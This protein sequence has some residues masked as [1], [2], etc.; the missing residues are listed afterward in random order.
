VYTILLST[1]PTKPYVREYAI[2]AYTRVVYSYS[3]SNM[4]TR[5]MHTALV[6]ALASSTRREYAYIQMCMS[7]LCIVCILGSNNTRYA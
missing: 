7:V 4:H 5:T 3:S 6:V 2:A 1:Y